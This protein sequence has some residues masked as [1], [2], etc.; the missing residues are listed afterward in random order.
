MVAK[1][2]ADASPQRRL[3]ISLIT[4]D[5][6][7]ADAILDIIDNSIN[8]ALEPMAAQLK[9]ADDYQRLL[10]NNRIKPKV[11]INV[12]VGSVRI[13]VDD[14]APGISLEMAKNQVFK[15]GRDKED[16]NPSDRL[17][18]YG[19]GLK[20]AIFKCGN[21]VTIT[22]DHKNGGFELKLPDVRAW[23]ADKSEH[24]TFPIT[25]RPPT[26]TNRGTRVM[27]TELHD[28]VLRRIDDGLFLTQLRDR[29]SKT[30]SVY[31]GRVVDI[32]LN[33]KP[34]EKEPFEIGGNR[35]GQKFKNGSVTCNVSAGI[36]V[37]PGEIFREK[38]AGWYV[39]CNGRAVLFADK[40][41]LTGWGAGLPLF[42]A[43]HRPFLGTVFFVSP[44]AE[45]LPWTTTKSSINEENAVWQEARGHM[46]SVG[47]TVTKF[48][49]SRYT[50]EGTLVSPSD[51]R[52]ATGEKMN[53]LDAAVAD[54][55][56][57]RPP[58]K[59][60]PKMTKIQYEAKTSDVKKI[61]DHLRR[62]MGGPEVG[63]YT[64]NFY[65]KNE[66]GDND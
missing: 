27:V 52:E 40:S 50:G 5:I 61:E 49:D 47:R 45:A 12:R 62:R 39:F 59:A 11:Q 43:K 13:A 60:V 4:R 46:I 66:V 41:S 17:S 53:F 63:L 33:N 28:D 31:I 35:A 58:A 26:K 65:L 64:F 2:L 56:A 1:I 9:T 37:I 25:P 34:I 51:L 55:S 20:R 14:N 44:D 42:Q 23:A 24:W 19:I 38:N 16:D 32:T 10:A 22:S 29:I 57:F 30:Y 36:A 18:V 7:L 48:L 54:E 8:A 21:R 3:F 6:S 15:F